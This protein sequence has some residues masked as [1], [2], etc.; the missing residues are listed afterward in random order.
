MLSSTGTSA[1][2]VKRKESYKG[3]AKLLSRKKENK[4]ASKYLKD[5]A[6]KG[7]DSAT[8]LTGETAGINPSIFECVNFPKAYKGIKGYLLPQG[9]GRGLNEAGKKVSMIVPVTGGQADPART[10]HKLTT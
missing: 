7:T 4:Q 2:L 10:R 6:S 8:P 9:K 1:S 5:T 3:V